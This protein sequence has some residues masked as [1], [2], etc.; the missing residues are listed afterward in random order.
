[1]PSPSQPAADLHRSAIVIDG[2]NAS[3][4]LEAR[5]F[6]RLH[7]GGVTAVHAT[8][9][10]WHDRAS[11][12]RLLDTMQRLL[13]ARRDLVLPVRS[14]GDIRRAKRS[15]QLGVIYG[16]QDI[17]PLDG[18]LAQLE[19]YG[20]LGVRVVQLT[21][22]EANAAGFGCAA[23]ED[24]GLTGFGRDAIAEMNRLGMLIDLSHC[25]P[26][27]TLEA[28]RRSRQPVAITHA[29]ATV[30]ANVPRNKPETIL[31]ELAERGGVVGAAAVPL[32]LNG[33]T[34][35][36]LADYIRAIDDLMRIAG[37]E[38]V[39]LGPDF[40]EAMPAEIATA[41]LASVPEPQRGLLASM[42]PPQG[43]A[44]ASE[45]PNLTE[46][47]LESGYAPDTI[48]R[49]LGENWLRLYERVWPAR[50]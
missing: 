42:Q 2:L 45:F 32:L 17:A 9:A 43:F 28:I 20:Q 14:T 30:T 29:N 4:F 41:A 49:V 31:R 47:L 22:N 3:W 25:G 46:A 18:D 7:A 12:Q 38:H 40:M 50:P 26:R 1:M 13:E 6:E 8:I 23:A 21:Y 35:A 10:A 16:F 24:R 27:T 11:T 36:T 33:T 39:G 15:G 48:R 19:I 34:R 5:V 44:S 37:E